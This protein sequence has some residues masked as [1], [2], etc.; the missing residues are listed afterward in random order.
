M[1]GGGQHLLASLIG[2]GD[3][4]SV[5]QGRLS[6]V[7]A[8]GRSIPDGW[9]KSKSR[10]LVSAAADLAGCVALEYVG[11]SVGTYP[12]SQGGAR[13][14][15]GVTLQFLCVSTGSPYYSVFNAE[16]YRKATTRHGKKGSRL[17]AG[18]FR[19]SKNHAFY[20]FWLST[21][22]SWHRRSDFHD[23]MG[24]LA[25]LVFTGSVSSGERIRA[26]SLAPLHLSAGDLAELVRSRVADKAPTGHRPLTDREPTVTSDSDSPQTQAVQGLRAGQGA[27]GLGYGEKVIRLSG[28]KARVDT[29]PQLQST[30]EWVEALENAERRS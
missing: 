23:Y 12:I 25:P 13:L 4:V 6:I 16:I 7:S 15:E 2:R 11:Y 5:E 3:A 22:L 19:V 18:H 21:G 14:A 27:G 1:N 28:Y 9:R 8:S 30:E 17:P 24:K 29:P 20:K 26:T 10:A